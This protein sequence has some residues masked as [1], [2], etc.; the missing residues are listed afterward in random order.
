MRKISLTLGKERAIAALLEKEAPKMCDAI[1]SF[2]PWEADTYH[3][4]ICPNELIFMMPAII[5]SMENP[6]LPGKGDVGYWLARQCVNIWYD[7]TQPL[8]KTELFAKIVENLEGF[9]KEARKVFK[10]PGVK[11]K[12]E[13]VEK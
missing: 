10:N 12:V 5:E 3:A 8:G 1:W 4:R 2:L 13:K 9:Q 6:V 7:D 11:I